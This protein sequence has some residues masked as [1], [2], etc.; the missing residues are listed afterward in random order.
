MLEGNRLDNFSLPTL[1]GQSWEFRRD[2]PRKLVLLDFWKSNCGPCLEAIPHL[3]RLQDAYGRDGLEV[4]GIAYED[5]APPADQSLHVHGVKSRLHV[6]YTI[7]IGADSA[8]SACPVRSQFLVDRFPHLVLIDETGDI[9]WRSNP[10]GLSD[11]QL[12]ELKRQIEHKLYRSS[13]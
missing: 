6:N 3:V 7:L 8:A 2:P 9:L 10:D 1:D 13:R 4:V 5:P 11:D 12:G